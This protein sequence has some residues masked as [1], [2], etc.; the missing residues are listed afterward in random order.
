MDE[1]RSMGNLTTAPPPPTEVKIRTMKSDIAMMAA[2]GGGGVPQFENVHVAGLATQN[3]SKQDAAT[4][5]VR[6]NS[7]SN[8]LLIV[9]LV[10]ALIALAVIGWFVYLRFKS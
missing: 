5:A 3:E 8:L 10:V 9:V 7:K 1:V 4:N 6:A 2:S